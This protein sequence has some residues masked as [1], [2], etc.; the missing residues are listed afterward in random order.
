MFQCKFETDFIIK[1]RSMF[2]KF[3]LV[4]VFIGHFE[5][6]CIFNQ[7]VPSIKYTHVRHWAYC[8]SIFLLIFISFS[9]FFPPHKINW[10]LGFFFSSSSF[11]FLFFFLL[12]LSYWAET[13]P[14]DDR[15]YWPINIRT[16]NL[17]CVC[18][19]Y[20][21]TIILL[22]VSLS[23]CVFTYNSVNFVSFFFVFC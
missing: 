14:I 17:R 8:N 22:F 13:P 20:D 3:H 16:R 11:F 4:A 5:A 10:V 9:L 6:H 23:N 2:S 18:T 12:C 15:V 21:L 1:W 7:C 19:R